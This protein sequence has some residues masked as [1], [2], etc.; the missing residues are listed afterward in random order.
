MKFIGQHDFANC[1][2]K[3][4]LLSKEECLVCIMGKS[5]SYAYKAK[6]SGR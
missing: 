3:N 4:Q 1:L 6:M 5:G 2:D